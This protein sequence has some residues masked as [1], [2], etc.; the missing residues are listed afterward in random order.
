MSLQYFEEK[1]SIYQNF[2]FLSQYIVC[3][4]IVFDVGLMVKF[5]GYKSHLKFQLLITFHYIMGISRTKL[6]LNVMSKLVNLQFLWKISI[7]SNLALIILNMSNIKKNF[8]KIRLGNFLRNMGDW[9]WG[10]VERERLI[11]IYAWSQRSLLYHNLDPRSDSF[12]GLIS[13]SFYTKI[14]R[15]YV[16]KAHKNT[17]YLTVFLR[18]WNL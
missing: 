14:L 4:N 1:I 16:P 9:I 7:K 12:P 13:S 6:H 2:F 11:C 15:T 3:K 5:R 17:A 8:T 18:I 10:G